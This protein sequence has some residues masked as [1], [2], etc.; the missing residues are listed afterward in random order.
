MGPVEAPRTPGGER[1]SVVGHP[2]PKVDAW[3]KVVGETRF[4][5][6]LALPR[7]AAAKLLRS[8]HPH[9]RIRHIDTSLAAGLPGVH[10]VITGRDFPPVKFGIMPVSQDEEPLSVDRVRFVGDPVAA[11]AAVDEETAEQA[12]R[13]IHVEYETLPALMSVDQ[14]LREGTPRIHDYGDGHNIHKVVSLEFGDVENVERRQ[15][16]APFSVSPPTPPG[17]PARPAPTA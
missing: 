16:K 14:S 13:L 5:D 1:L 8:P 15:R 6:D 12:T 17:P 7:M 10:A 11:V 9:A 2:L 4:A 3:A